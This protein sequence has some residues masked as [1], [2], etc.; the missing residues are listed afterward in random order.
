MNY[1]TLF[2]FEVMQWLGIS[3]CV[4]T[5]LAAFTG[6]VT[7]KRKIATWGLLLLIYLFCYNYLFRYVSTLAKNSLDE[8]LKLGETSLIGVKFYGAEALHGIEI[9]T[10]GIQWF[11]ESIKYIFFVLL[12]F[13][14]KHEIK[15]A[16]KQV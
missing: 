15:L 1:S 7:C 14:I 3:A 8:Y 12:V 6:L 11:L 16:G 9:M 5:A 10:S 13:S 4:A 2:T